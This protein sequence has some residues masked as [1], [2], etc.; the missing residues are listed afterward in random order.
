MLV[1]NRREGEAILIGDNVR[2]VVV[3]FSGNRVQLGIAADDHIRVL[4]EEVALRA[5]TGPQQGPA[6]VGRIK[7]EVRAAK[8]DIGDVA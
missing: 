1:L 3:G 5:A 4:R 2:V 8:M 6:S 7:A